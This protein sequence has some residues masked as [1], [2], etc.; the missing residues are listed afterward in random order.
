M[1]KI[2]LKI[3]LNN[4][5]KFELKFKYKLHITETFLKFLNYKLD[6]FTFFNNLKIKIIQEKINK[7]V[8][9]LPKM[10]Y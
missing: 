9:V 7:N 6:N 4:K 10:K 1:K 8:L 2:Y 5:F 3:N